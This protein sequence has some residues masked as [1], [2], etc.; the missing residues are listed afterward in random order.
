MSFHPLM[1]KLIPLLLRQLPVNPTVVELGNQTFDPTI[2]GQLSKPEDQMLPRVEEYLEKRDIPFDRAYVNGLSRLSAEAL[3]PCTEGYFRALGFAS[4]TSIDVNS[5][6]SSLVMDLNVDLG[7]AYGY[8]AQ[9]DLVT[10]N[11]TGEHIFN[12]FTVFKNMHQ[13]CRPGGLLL[14]VLPFYNWMNH[15]FFNFNPILFTDL[16]VANDYQVVRLSVACSVGQEATAADT[17]TGSEEIRLPWQP[18]TETL[19]MEDFP[20]RGAIRPHTAR[21]VA[22]SFVDTFLG[23]GGQP[24]QASKLPGVVEKFASRVTN[25]NVVAALRKTSDRPLQMPLQGMYSESNVES[26]AIRQ[27][28]H[29]VRR[30]V[31]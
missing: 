10:N 24:G 2:S 28:Y 25:I 14:F 30:P 31:A 3:K 16:A 23:R 26:D 4:Y 22:G 29:V 15:G 11:G 20:K 27:R 9:F 21:N 19:L 6:Y 12:Q 7:D 8:N 5:V 13:L 18:R 1:I 17:P